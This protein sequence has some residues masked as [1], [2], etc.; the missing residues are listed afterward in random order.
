MG[1]TVFKGACPFMTLPV[2]TKM[3]S[4]AYICIVRLLSYA[5]MGCTA[6]TAF[7]YVQVFKLSNLPSCQVA[8]VIMPSVPA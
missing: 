5:Y 1:T 7:L 2:M 8:I 3:P 6:S 4:I